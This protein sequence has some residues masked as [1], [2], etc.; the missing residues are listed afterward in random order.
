[1]RIFLTGGTGFV[2]SN[3]L[4]YFLDN[5]HNVTALRR[6]YESKP[7]VILDRKPNWILGSFSDVKKKHLENIDLIVHLAAHSAQPPY[8]SLE[9]CILN[10]VLEPIKLFDKGFDAGIRK[11]L[12]AGS[13]FEYGLSANF[14]DFIPPTAPLLPLDSYSSSKAMASI[15]FIQ[16]AIE[17]KVSLSIQ[18]LFHLYGRGESEKRFFPSL[19]KAALS[20]KDFLMSGGEQIRDICEINFATKILYEECNRISNSNKSDVRIRNIGSGQQ[21]SLKQFALNLW[22]ELNAKGKLKIGDLPYRDREIMRYVPN[23]EEEYIINSF[24]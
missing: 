5:N 10:N 22:S 12:V 23:L 19:K 17:K 18:R 11:I 2:G 16:W 4:K 13:C 15:A 14:Y 3:L 8:D 24:E 7:K 21:L 20:G 1:M 9:E 6:S